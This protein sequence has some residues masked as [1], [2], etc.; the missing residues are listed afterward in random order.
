MSQA[1]RQDDARVPVV[2]FCEEKNRLMR[3]FLAAIHE[4][5]EIQKQQTQAVI[6]RDQDFARFDVLLHSAN[7]RKEDA[8]YAWIMSRRN[9]S[10]TAG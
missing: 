10:P 3:E 5:V 6:D 1:G 8:K 9:A 4:L 2:G 7:E